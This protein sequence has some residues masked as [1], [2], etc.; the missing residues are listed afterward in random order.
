L[1]CLVRETLAGEDILVPSG[2]HLELEADEGL[3]SVEVD[4]GQIRQVL[5]SLISNAVEAVEGQG[6]RIRVRSGHGRLAAQAA[7][8]AFRPPGLKAGNGT[9]VFM[10]VIDDGQGIE[11]D[12]LPRIFEPFFSTRFQGR[13]LGLAAAL[14]IV[15]AHHGVIEVE[16][17]PGE[18]TSVRVHLPAA[19]PSEAG[20]AEQAA[21]AS[22]CKGRGTVLVVDDEAAVVE[23]MSRMLKRSGFEVLTASGEGQALE[24]LRNGG[25]ADVGAVLLDYSVGGD[26]PQVVVGSLRAAARRAPLIVMSGYPREEMADSLQD[27]AVSGFLEKPF[28]RGVLVSE[29]ERVLGQ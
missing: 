3:P 6:G 22:S 9:Y 23:I 1:S 10:E 5:R 8:G 28:D 7:P 16:T 11:R 13:G 18:G 19:L 15:R 25:G 2:C 24:L 20:E 14:G 17:T 26:D 12:H 27:L 29:I 4:R 21:D